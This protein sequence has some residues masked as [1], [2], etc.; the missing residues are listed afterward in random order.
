MRGGREEGGGKEGGEEGGGEG[1]VEEGGG[2]GGTRWQGSYTL[3]RCAH[4]L[5]LS[6]Q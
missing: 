3:Y 1:R 6:F 2:E 5:A 4:T